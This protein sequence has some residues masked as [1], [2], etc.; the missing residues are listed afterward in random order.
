MTKI[1]ELGWSRIE[2]DLWE[3]RQGSVVWSSV[4]Q[5]EKGWTAL[6]AIHTEGPFDTVGQAMDAAEAYWKG[7]D[8]GPLAN[9]KE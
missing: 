4:V 9:D 7:Q 6:S 2:T 3:L 1:D 5:T 8:V